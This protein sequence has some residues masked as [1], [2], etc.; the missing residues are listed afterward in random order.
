MFQTA[1]SVAWNIQCAVCPGELLFGNIP[2][3]ANSKPW[4]PVGSAVWPRARETVS[5]YQV[6]Q[7]GPKYE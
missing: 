3:V 4:S 5:I 6:T 7:V 2:S 1:R